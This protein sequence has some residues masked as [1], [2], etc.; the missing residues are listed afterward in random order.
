M[1]K[2]PM[3]ACASVFFVCA[4]VG[5]A[6]APETTEEAAPAAVPAEAAAPATPAAPE[7]S[8]EPALKPRF[9]TPV[10]GEAALG[11]TKPVVKNGTIGGQ[12]FVI[13]TMQVKNMDV[14]SI[15][16]LMVDEFWYDAAGNAVTGDNY[17]HPTPLQPG[18][19]ITITL[20]TPVDPRM[21][22]NQ[23]SFTHA[24]GDI[25]AALQGTL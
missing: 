1:K 14:G 4:A 10:R 7:E 19:V 11:Y 15:A 5:C 16:G 24:N 2:H 22:R 8:A 6:G 18:E 3:L 20:E 12:E 25:R 9:V 13:T 17:R 23:Y 21:D